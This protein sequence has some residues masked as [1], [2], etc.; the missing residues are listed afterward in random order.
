[1]SLVMSHA[2]FPGNPPDPG[3]AAYSIGRLGERRADALSCAALLAP[4][5]G[6][7]ILFAPW[8]AL[9]LAAGLAAAMVVAGAAHLSLLELLDHCALFATTSTLPDVAARQ[10]RLTSPRQRRALAADLRSM[11]EERTRTAPSLQP[12]AVQLALPDR[13]RAR[14]RD[15]LEL[16][17]LV[18]RTERPDPVAVARTAWLIRD[19]LHSPLHNPAVPAEALGDAIHHA[20]LRFMLTQRAC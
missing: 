18:E 20:R 2:G 14:R 13:I 1:M 4:G 16:A 8:L 17:D 3:D 10:R 7:A 5:L 12:V 9:P 11:V 19:A 6:V 15:L